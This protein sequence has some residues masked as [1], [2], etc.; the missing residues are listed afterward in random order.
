MPSFLG[1]ERERFVR[2]C[3]VHG[4]PLLPNLACPSGGHPTTAEREAGY[5]RNEPPPWWV[6][7]DTQSD[8][9]AATVRGFYVKWEPGYDD[10]ITI[11]T[12]HGRSSA[13]FTERRPRR[14]QAA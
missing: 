11:P 2:L 9:K 13:G 8:L 3:S 4:C 1:K 5:K 14:R 7:W 6:L 12:P 10:Y